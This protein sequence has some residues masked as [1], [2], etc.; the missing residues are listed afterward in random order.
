M[1]GNDRDQCP[2]GLVW[3]VITDINGWCKWNPDI[4][5]S[6]LEGDLAP[7]NHFEWKSGGSAIL[8]R[9]HTVAAKSQFGWSGKTLGICAVHNWTLFE[10]SGLVTVI[11]EESMEGILARLLKG[12]LKKKTSSSLKTWLQRLKE[13]SEDP[14][15]NRHS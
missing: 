13:V 5:H 1:P 15:R 9:L 6:K 7:E 10:Q 2:L 8:S 3:N 4:T 12:F 11:S 14:Y